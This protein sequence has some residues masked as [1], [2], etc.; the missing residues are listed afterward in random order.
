VGTLAAG[1]GG[2]PLATAQAL[3]T[4]FASDSGELPEDI[5]L[6]DAE[7]E[8]FFTSANLVSYTV[9]MPFTEV[10]SFYEEEMIAN[11]WSFIDEG[12]LVTTNTAVSNYQQVGRNALLT[13]SGQADGN[14]TVV[15]IILQ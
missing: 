10:L 4:Q 5:P 13:I 9:D 2:D 12:S 3:A 7:L 6:P 11:G 14:L 15:Q 1:E 8:N